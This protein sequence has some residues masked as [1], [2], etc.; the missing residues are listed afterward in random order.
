MVRFGAFAVAATLS[1]G[2]LGS[3]YWPFGTDDEEEPR[4]ADLIEPAS[5]N[6][7]AAADCVADGKID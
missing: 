7:D 1:L 4:L 6:I 2:A 5:T 3:W